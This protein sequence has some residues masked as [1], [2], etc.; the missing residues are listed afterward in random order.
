MP[1]FGVH[2]AYYKHLVMRRT[3]FT[4]FCLLLFLPVF[5]QTRDILGF[6]YSWDSVQAA[7]RIKKVLSFTWAESS[8]LM[9]NDLVVSV[10]GVAV[11]ATQNNPEFL[12]LL[13]GDGLSPVE[14]GIRRNGNLQTYS[15]KRTS[16]NFTPDFARNIDTVFQ[17]STRNWAGW[18][19]GSLPDFSK[20]GLSAELVEEYY[21][22][23]YRIKSKQFSSSYEAEAFMRNWIIQMEVTV[24]DDFYTEEARRNFFDLGGYALKRYT[25]GKWISE[26]LIEFLLQEPSSGVYEVHCHV[27]LTDRNWLKIVTGAGDEASRNAGVIS[28]LEKLLTASRQG[29]SS[30]K[31]AQIIPEED[32]EMSEE[33]FTSRVAI[34]DLQCWLTFEDMFGN[35]RP[36]FHAQMTVA[37]KADA[38][39]WFTYFMNN[40][41]LVGQAQGLYAH[42]AVYNSTQEFFTYEVGTAN[43]AGR[44]I[45]TTPRIRIKMEKSVFSGYYITVEVI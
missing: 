22:Q 37:N 9:S 10:N 42:Y 15:V 17:Q 35:S 41:R 18:A 5:G 4:C 31:G 30:I 32:W 21:E 14:L 24:S 12:R 27:Y 34:P 6:T 13:S 25:P 43:E 3:I 28:A 38:V 33:K 39:G 26:T 20:S 19:L 7:Y 2:L 16:V 40:A 8:G 44:N 11:S 23:W 36:M 45:E 29:F 1:Q